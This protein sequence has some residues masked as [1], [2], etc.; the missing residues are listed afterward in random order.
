M[1]VLNEEKYHITSFKKFVN[2]I[3]ERHSPNIQNQQK[4]LF[5][6]HGSVNHKLIPG[7]G[8]LLGTECFPTEGEVYS[9]EKNAFYAE[10]NCTGEGFQP[11]NRVSW[12]RQLTKKEAEKYSKENILKDS[13]ANWYVK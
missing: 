9:A 3:E 2:L 12:S 5:R 8:R 11:K 4:R 13:I 1:L 7:I 10:Y 6:G